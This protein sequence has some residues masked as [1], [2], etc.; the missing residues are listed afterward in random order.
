MSTKT[1]VAI[2]IAVVMALT[3]LG[4]FVYLRYYAEESTYDTLCSWGCVTRDKVE[5]VNLYYFVDEFCVTRPRDI[6]PDDWNKCNESF[7]VAED[8]TGCLA[9]QVI[10]L[11]KRCWGIRGSGNLDVGN[12]DC[13]TMTVLAPKDSKYKDESICVS[14][15][16]LR[17]IAN[18]YGPPGEATYSD[19]LGS[20]GFTGRATICKL[21]EWTIKYDEDYDWSAIVPY[22]ASKDGISMTY[23]GTSK[24]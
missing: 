5:F 1:I 15:E 23:E 19:Y 7:K 10:K 13:Y 2:V 12:L 24:K 14:P 8:P 6:R 3:A 16:K 17:E 21:E 20:Y 4:L 11:V 22:W 18:A 9:E